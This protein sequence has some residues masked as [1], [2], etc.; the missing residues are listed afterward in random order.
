MDDKEARALRRFNA[1]RD[2]HLIRLLATYTHEGRFN[3]IFP[4]ADGN[5]KDLWMKPEF[6]LT[7]TGRDA[8][9][10]K[11]MA[12]QLLGL[13]RALQMIHYCPIEK[14][15]VEDLPAHDKKQLYG[16][17]GDLKPENILWF[18]HDEDDHNDGTI[19]ILKI[20]DFGFADF[21]SK[22]SKSNIR[23]S[24]VGGFTDTYKAPEYEIGS[25]LSQQYDIWSF[26]CILLQFV[27]WH[28]KGWKGVDDFSK[29][30]TE[31]SRGALMAADIF[32]HLEASSRDTYQARTSPSVTKVRFSNSGGAGFR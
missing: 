25:L 24:A 29:E 1:Q 9:R 23:K 5:L 30:R 18:R 19:G 31:D 15:N 20:A 27:V 6:Q 22:H 16:R 7:D 12:A 2:P 11:W 10:V 4:W 32:F 14:D 26:G 13:A 17:H 3:L 8:W 21:H 28:L